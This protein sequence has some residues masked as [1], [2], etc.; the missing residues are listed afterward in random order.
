MSAVIIGDVEPIRDFIFGPRNHDE[1]TRGWRF[2]KYLADHTKR[3]DAMMEDG[4]RMIA[5]ARMRNLVTEYMEER[6]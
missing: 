5:Q 6:T 2:H 4:R 1:H 3:C